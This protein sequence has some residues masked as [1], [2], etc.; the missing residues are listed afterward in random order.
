V[1]VDGDGNLYIADYDNFVVRRV[2]QSGVISTIAGNGNDFVY[3]GDGGQALSAQLDPIR[4]AVSGT[5]VLVADAYNDR[6]RKLAPQTPVLLTLSGGDNQT[7]LAGTLFSKPL[8]VTVADNAGIPVA[9]VTVTFRVTV[10]S[11]TLDPSSAVT[12]AD[13]TA[14]THVTAGGP[15]GPITVTATATGLTA[16]TFH[17]STTA[18]PPPGTISD[19]GVVGAGLS[20]PA[21]RAISP[22]AL[23]S[24]F[25]R[26][27][28]PA[29]TLTQVGPADLVNGK[30]PTNLMD[31]CVLVDNIAAPL[32]AITESQ[33][34]FQA[35][36][37]PAAG[38]VSVQVA[39]GC[40][41]GTQVL[42]NAISI[43]VQTTTP[44]F[45][46]FKHSEDGRNPIAAVNA[47][48]GTYIGAPG[49]LPGATLVPAKPGE[50]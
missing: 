21:V 6:V 36:V 26:N 44:E 3:A 29:G 32:L 47:V 50:C 12:G 43:S 18:A 38:T 7:G 11:A 35:P 37:L 48:S 27:F 25:G 13:G 28:A 49:L 17:L 39:T 30:L 5:T 15:A 40:G 33:V 19:G 1:A 23:M 45:F 24:V 31:V 14:S 42:S 41:T 10:G 4:V 9:G 16:T 34:N 20:L 2:S 8:S 46:Y 22:N